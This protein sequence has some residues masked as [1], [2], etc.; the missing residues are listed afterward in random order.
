MISAVSWPSGPTTSEETKKKKTV[1]GGPACLIHSIPHPS[2]THLQLG[3]Q[4]TP[5]LRRPMKQSP[6]QSNPIDYWEVDYWE[7]L[8]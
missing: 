1:N 2:Q 4:L 3:F 5:A 8:V 6:L 7:V